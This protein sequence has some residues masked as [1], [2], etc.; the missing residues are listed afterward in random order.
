MRMAI[1]LR[2][3][4]AV[5]A[6]ALAAACDAAPFA[7]G[8]SPD[9]PARVRID[10]GVS[11]LLEGDTARLGLT[12]F[13]AANQPIPVPAW[14]APRWTTQSAAV[15]VL[16]DGT[17]AAETPGDAVVRVEVAGLSAVLPLRVDPHV[18]TL[19]VPGA[20]LVQTVQRVDGS[21]PLMAGRD[22]L[23]RVFV[24]GNMALNEY[25]PPVRV[26]FYRDGDPVHELVVPAGGHRIPHVFSEGYMSGSWSVTVPGHLVQPGLG[27]SVVVD[28]DG[29][30]ERSA[31]ST[32][33]FP[34]AGG[35]QPVD[36]RPLP[37]HRVRFVPIRQ[38]GTGTT[39]NV[40]EAN[41]ESYLDLFR[42][43][44][45]VP[46]VEIEVRAPYTTSA[47]VRE[48]DGWIQLLQEMAL[49]RTADGSSRYYYGVV[50]PAGGQWGGYAFI[51]NPVAVGYDRPDPTARGWTWAAALFAHEVGHNFGRRHAP[52]G[53]AQGTDPEYP[54]PG[55]TIG[56]FGYDRVRD[57]ILGAE[58]A[59]DIMSYCYEWISD[60]TYE[61]VWSFRAAEADRVAADPADRP[62][63][64]ALLVWGRIDPD[65]SLRLEPAFE[66]VVPPAPPSP[67]PYQIR[68]YDADGR[69][70]FVRSFAGHEVAH[71]DGT[72][73]FSFAIPLHGI[74][75]GAVRRLRLAGPDRA[76]ERI[77]GDV[78]PHEPAALLR[79][80]AT[81]QILAIGRPHEVA[82]TDHPGPVDLVLSSGTGSLVARTRTP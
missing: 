22:A 57:M 5:A 16:G 40:T 15:T 13:D 45:P 41:A 20:Y 67:G 26:R 60:Y 46:D 39:G 21:I 68:G 36:V 61:A 37:P 64:R 77:A 70:L 23:L 31:E 8:A 78:A 30:V 32:I 38:T 9:P 72:R 4:A 79:D 24:V 49:L 18:I 28:P 82:G 14:A 54:Y 19:D 69:L 33:R 73:L 1:R 44:F 42:R 6:V 12:V 27:F 66:L 81:G 43:I 11:R 71:A 3:L 80:P 50:R 75:P 48:T 47:E 10:G 62:A 51:G 76:V 34:R 7:P 52:C 17:V 25:R 53:G 59:R 2:P 74:G 65:G 56:V 63:E 58:T 55:A 29:T 35:I